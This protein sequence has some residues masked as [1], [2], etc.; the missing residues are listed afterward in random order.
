MIYDILTIYVCI[1]A[2]YWVVLGS[3]RYTYRYAMEIEGKKEDYQ[4]I[5]SK[6]P[7]CLFLGELIIAWVVI[8]TWPILLFIDSVCILE[9]D[10]YD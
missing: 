7:I 5:A 1:G 8:K 4:D 9:G 3:Q 10:D 6:T 2:L